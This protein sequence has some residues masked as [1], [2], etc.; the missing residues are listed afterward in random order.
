LNRGVHSRSAV[1]IHDVAAV[2]KSGHACDQ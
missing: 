2:L 1:G